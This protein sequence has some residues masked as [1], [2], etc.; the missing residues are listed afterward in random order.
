MNAYNSPNVDIGLTGPE[1]TSQTALP[2]PHAWYPVAKSQAIKSGK[3]QALR[4]M[5]RDWLLF[6]NQRGQVAV[7]ARHCSHMGAD[8]NQGQVVDDCIR[9]PLHGW[10]FDEQGQCQTPLKQ[11]FKQ[12]AQLP[13]LATAEYAG[14]VYVFTQ[15]QAMY[16]LPQL[17][18]EPNCAFSSTRKLTLPIHF[19]LASMNSFDVAHYGYVHHRRI[20]G[21]PKVCSDDPHH[22]G[23]ELQASVIRKNW[24]D[25]LMY[26]LGFKEVSIRIDCWGTSLLHMY[27]QQAKMGA[28]IAVMPVDAQHSEVYITAYD[29]QS[30]KRLLKRPF[31]ALKLELSRLITTAFLK[32]D[33]PIGQGLIPTEG[34]LIPGQDD[35]VKQFWSYYKQLPKVS[36]HHEN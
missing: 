2:L 25:K 8:L 20:S 27:N 30:N 36:E 5:Q 10:R 29:C 7:V 23:I 26:W 21:K 13:S 9:C 18:F 12:Q 1:Q 3:K 32:S 28:V 31:K 16:P 11:P 6:R 15:Q 4:F 17:P 14:V 22:L 24:Q 19:M 35:E 33:V 34:V